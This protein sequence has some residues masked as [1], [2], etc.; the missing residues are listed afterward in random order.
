MKPAKL[1]AWRAEVASTLAASA[2]DPAP[3][4]PLD[5]IA[6]QPG[7]RDTHPYVVSKYGRYHVVA[8]GYP[9]NPRLWATACGWGFGASKEARPAGA[10]PTF[11]KAYC[12]R[13]LTAEREQAKAAARTRVSED[14]QVHKSPV[15]STSTH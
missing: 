9:E 5:A 7:T 11:Y 8:V 6:I 15:P 3:V 13:C 12:E 2:V 4:P 1:A 10:L 14:G